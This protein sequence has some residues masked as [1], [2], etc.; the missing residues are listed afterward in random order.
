MRELCDYY[1]IYVDGRHLNG[2]V[3]ELCVLFV[4]G[5]IDGDSN[6]DSDG[7]RDGDNDGDSNGY[8]DSNGNGEN[9][10]AGTV[11]L[12]AHGDSV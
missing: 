3:D 5:D 12:T 10:G 6:G 4:I 7:D 9:D 11:T 8:G 1:A 2:V